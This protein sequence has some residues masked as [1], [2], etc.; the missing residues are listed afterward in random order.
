M[1]SKQVEDYYEAHRNR[2]AVT[3]P[4]GTPEV[5]RGEKHSAAPVVG[6][7]Q[8]RLKREWERVTDADIGSLCRFT[9]MLPHDGCKDPGFEFGIFLGFYDGPDTVV[10]ELADGEHMHFTFG[11]KQVMT[12]EF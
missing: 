3:K 11:Q 5:G 6:D 9:D 10:C 4:E 8:G 12:L 2:D 1:P 7:L